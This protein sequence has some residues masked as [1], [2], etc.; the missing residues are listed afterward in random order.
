MSELIKKIKEENKLQ[1]VTFYL[2]YLMIFFFKNKY[3][4]KIYNG[5]GEYE[6]QYII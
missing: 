3:Q 6:F 1:F 2:T 5:L 4:S